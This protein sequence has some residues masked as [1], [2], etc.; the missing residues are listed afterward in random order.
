MV[1]ISYNWLQQHIEQKL[2]P[3]QEVA[4]TIHAHAFEIEHSTSSGD[5]TVFD[6]A[7][8]PDRAGDCLSHKGMAREVAGLLRLTL[9]DKQYPAFPPKELPAF[10]VEVQDNRCDVYTATRIDGV[11]VGPSPDWLKKALE[12]IGQKSINNVVDATNFVLHDSGQPVHVFD[13]AKIDGGIVVRSAKEGETIKLLG[14][15]EKILKE[16]DMVIA[17]YLGALAIAG[18]KGGSTAEVTEATTS[19]VIEVAH[20]DAVAVR[21][22]SRRLGLITDASKRFENHFSRYEVVPALQQVV[23]LIQELAGGTISATTLH[24][25]ELPQPNTLSFSLP[26]IARLL[27]TSITETH[28]DDVLSRYRY[29]YKKE[30]GVYSLSIPYWRFDITGIHDVAEEIGRVVGYDTIPSMPLP[31]SVTTEINP[32]DERIRAI[33]AWALSEGYRE[34]YTYTFRAKGEVL[35]AYGAKGKEAL[36]TNLSLGLK[37]SYELNRLNAPL[38][39]LTEV[40]LF[41]IGTVFFSDREA[42]HVA[43]CDKG[44]IQELSLDDFI[45]EKNITLET[46]IPFATISTTTPFVSWSSYPH[47]T[48]DIAVWI[49]DDHAR[50]KLLEVAQEFSAKHCVRPAF[51]FDEFSKEG[52]TSVALRFV[53]QAPDRTLTDEGV[54][55]QF[56][57]FVTTVG[58]IAGAAIR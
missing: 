49:S 4:D 27:G 20:F 48:R 56:D 9:K 22:A 53:F 46:P 58:T 10:S 29:E 11:T 19:I 39:G 34:V 28:I 21:K 54:T 57:H 33:R 23:A 18:V 47:V 41:E 42:T 37:E 14:G 51:I 5:D 16:T 7:V 40:K 12:S 15:E 31:F 8:L 50:T 13:A 17:D 52:K 35:V 3:A 1:K 44:T 55:Q 32:I 43:L 24:G 26:A 25:V 38:L 2:P 6:I 36:R 45:K 30:N